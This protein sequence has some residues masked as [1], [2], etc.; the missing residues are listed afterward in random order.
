M[1]FTIKYNIENK[2]F[3]FDNDF[4]NI[5]HQSDL[6]ITRAGASTLAELSLMNIP[7][8]CSS[9]CQLQKITINLKMQIFTKNKDCCWIIDQNDFEEKIEEYLNN[10][11][12]NKNEYLKIKENLKK[13][14]FQN[15]WINVN[16]KILK[17]LNEN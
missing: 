14:N 1:N 16:Q 8:H 17:N 11:I 3:S 4:A 9:H 12:K 7:F 15:T 10:I 2:I 5:I 6:C 13:L